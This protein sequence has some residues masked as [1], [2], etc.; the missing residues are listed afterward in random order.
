MPH[1]APIFKQ[2]LTVFSILLLLTA[3]QN[4][5][6][7]T[8]RGKDAAVIDSLNQQYRY[9]V[10]RT[11]S[12]AYYMKNLVLSTDRKTLEATLDTLPYEHRLHLVKGI[13]GNM[14]YRKN[15]SSDLPVLSE[16]HLYVTS[17]NTAGVGSRYSLPLDQVQM[18]E[19]IEKD[20][21]RTTN[22]YVLGAIGVTV[23]AFALAA[24][25]IAATKSSCPFVSAYDG[26]QFT[27]QGEI[28]GGA[29]YP[30]LA[31][32]DFLPLKMTPLPDSSL[33]LKISNE[34][35]ERQY[36]DVAELWVI[37]HSK[38]I[39]VL[40]DEQGNLYS[41]AN[42]EAPVSAQLNNNKDV[43]TALLHAGDNA[44]LYMDDSTSPSA[45]NEVVIKFKKPAD[46]RK[47][48]LVL[49]LKNSYWLDLLYGELAKGF[50]SYYP[51]YM[52][53]QQG[54]PAAELLKWT[55][56]Q[57]IPLEV[58][59]K[60]KDGWKRMTRITTVGP[61]A[62][63]QVVV[64]I[65]MSE[66][67]GEFVDVRLSCGFMFWEIDYAAID[68]SEE[69]AFVVQKLQPV[70]AKDETGKDVLAL[71]QTEDRQY[72]EQP[73]IGNVATITY[74]GASTPGPDQAQTF[75]L[76]T[77]GYYEHIRNFENK[78]DIGFLQQFKK[79]G[80]FPVYG[81]ALYKKISAENLKTLA[82][83]N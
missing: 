63:R 60:T 9:F 67:T 34:L 48:K 55:Y 77:K 40:T 54:K 61:L 69:N 21:K 82:R 75:I 26:E 11:G 70:A 7:A 76:K 73:H 38:N 19:V 68:Y 64:P 1:H 39:R 51:K 81:M 14:R 20:R 74:K 43:T 71:L 36:T 6:K 16:V 35:Q 72:L 78:P 22:S 42:Q 10:L 56:E 45:S 27:L 13:N 59:V 17:N 53:Q 8:T 83:S 30:Q 47:G 62:T 31:R 12:E 66:T 57:Q 15:N 79:P 4:Y 37:T 33:Q 23:G 58:S 28:Y 52:K 44:L 3:C 32:K 41:V 80:A 25:I 24:I 49:S 18:I 46:N 50:G 29:I 5:Y 65:D 2:I